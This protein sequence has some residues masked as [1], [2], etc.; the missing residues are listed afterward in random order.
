MGFILID[1]VILI[2][3]KWYDE[4]DCWVFW[5]LCMYCGEFF[6]LLWEY[7]DWKLGKLDMVV[8]FCLKC[9]LE[10]QE[11]YKFVMVEEGD[12]FVMVFYI[13]GYVGFWFNVL[14]LMFFN[15]SWVKFIEEYENVK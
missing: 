10:I 4:L 13:I 6:E 3:I 8:C 1:E 5:M 9:G 7:L 14:I 11:W 12:W 15:V 2:I